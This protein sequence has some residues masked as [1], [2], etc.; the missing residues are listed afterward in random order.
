MT[1]RNHCHFCGKGQ[2]QVHALWAK[3]SGRAREILSA[4]LFVPAEAD[5]VMRAL[6]QFFS[7]VKP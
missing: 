6:T 3:D 1:E 2:S 4:L 5:Q 7:E